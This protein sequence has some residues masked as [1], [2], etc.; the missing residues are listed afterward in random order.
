MNI[1]DLTRCSYGH[2]EIFFI[3]HKDGHCPLCNIIAKNFDT[4]IKLAIAEINLDRLFEQV[5]EIKEK[6]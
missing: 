3:V 2:E 1:T 4:K 5:K 6:K